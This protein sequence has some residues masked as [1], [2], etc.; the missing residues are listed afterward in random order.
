M[1]K[2][3]TLMLGLSLLIGATAMFADDAKTTDTTKPAKAKKAKK[4]KK[5]STTASTEKKS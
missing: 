5:T 3:M 1:K 4:A 2:I